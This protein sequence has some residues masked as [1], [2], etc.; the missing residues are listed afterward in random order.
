MVFMRK[1]L[2]KIVEKAVKDRDVLAVML[3]G[4]CVRDEGSSDVDVC[5]VLYAGK[6]SRLFLSEKRLEYLKDFPSLDVQ[7]FQQLPL[8]IRVRVFKEGKVV[9]CKDEDKLYDLSFLTIR[10]YEYFKPVYLSYLEGVL[11]A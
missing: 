6:F 3:F 11:N 8:Y 7:V 2:E 1:E 5:V 9:L 4:S 10:E